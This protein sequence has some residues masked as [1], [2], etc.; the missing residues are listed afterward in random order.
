MLYSVLKVTVCNT[1]LAN[2]KYAWNPNK[3]HDKAGQPRRKFER[4]DPYEKVGS[5]RK[6]SSDS[7]DGGT[8][9]R[10]GEKR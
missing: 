6:R 9:K 1:Y 2:I 5:C 10:R 4:S 3:H 8:E 7:R